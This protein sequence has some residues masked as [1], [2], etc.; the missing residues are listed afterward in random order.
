MNFFSTW[1]RVLK[2]AAIS[3]SN[4]RCSTLGAAL[5]YYTLFSLAPLLLITI[6]II[7]IVFGADSARTGVIDQL[8]ETAG[9]QT[10]EAIDSILKSAGKA[11]GTTVT[12][13]G[14]VLLL[15]GAIGVFVELQDALNQIW[16]T[17]R[18]RASGIWGWVRIR[19]LALGAVF[20]TGLLLLAS[21]A[22]SSVVEGASG[23]VEKMWDLPGGAG[24]WRGVSLGV[25]FALVVLVCALVFRFLPNTRVT[26]RDVSGGAL[27]TGLLFALGKYFFS[28]Y[29]GHV[30]IASMYGAAGSVVLVL[31]WVYYSAQILLFGAEVT[32][33]YAKEAGSLKG[34]PE[35]GACPPAAAAQPP[36]QKRVSAS[37]RQPA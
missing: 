37:S 23:R 29:L 5:S 22:V 20:T 32:H 8:R 35:E 21:L 11:G 1:K 33:A 15:F 34:V 2:N 9:P 12:V 13:L 18:P 16:R 14:V 27:L 6:G 28:I 31:V 25:T 10:A 24:L 4:D 17:N 7:G 26:W 3:W 36:E 19:L 30:A